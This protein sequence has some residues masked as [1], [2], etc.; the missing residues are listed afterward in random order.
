MGKIKANIE[1]QNLEF[2][3]LTK[4]KLRITCSYDVII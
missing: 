1:I 2:E 3:L 4:K